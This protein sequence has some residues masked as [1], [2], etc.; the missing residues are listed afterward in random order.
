MIRLSGKEVKDYFL[1]IW[2]IRLFNFDNDNWCIIFKIPFITLRETKI[3][4][5]QF[6]FLHRLLATNRLLFLMGKKDSQICTFCHR[7]PETIEHLFWECPMTSSFLL[8]S[9]LLFFGNQFI[10]KKQDY[11]FGY[12]LLLDHPMNYFI[13]HLKY[14]IYNCKLNEKLPSCNEFWFKLKFALKVEAYINSKP[15]TS[16][17]KLRKFNALKNCFVHVP[18]LFES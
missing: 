6:K 7:D 9:E 4:Y 8:D 14:Y 11:F 5:F 16:Q 1:W 17:K 13:L 12:N 15:D 18:S 10:L 3:Q 2:E